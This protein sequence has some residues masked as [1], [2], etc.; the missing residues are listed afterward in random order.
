VFILPIRVTTGK[1]APRLDFFG[2]FAIKWE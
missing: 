1:P 2:L